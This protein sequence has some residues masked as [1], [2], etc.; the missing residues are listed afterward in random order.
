MIE[1]LNVFRNKM[2]NDISLFVFIVGK[3]IHANLVIKQTLGKI[4][5]ICQ[6]FNRHYVKI[7]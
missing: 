6:N 2:T 7:I 5:F 3:L 4:S 1:I